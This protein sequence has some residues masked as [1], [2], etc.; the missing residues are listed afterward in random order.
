MK[1]YPKCIHSCDGQI[2]EVGHSLSTHE[3]VRVTPKA[4]VAYMLVHSD[5]RGEHEEYD[6]GDEA[7]DEEYDE[8]YDEAWEVPKA[9]KRRASS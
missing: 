4:V 8:E 7:Y 5:P 2:C 9:K 3:K 6:S 1:T